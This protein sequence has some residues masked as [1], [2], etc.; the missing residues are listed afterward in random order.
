VA[1]P[2]TGKI[3]RG[4]QKQYSLVQ[5]ALASFAVSLP[6][7]L[8]GQT[9]HLE[10]DFAKLTYGDQGQRS[11]QKVA[12]SFRAADREQFYV[13]ASRFK[14]ALTIYTDDKRQLLAAVSKS[15][16]PPSATDLVAKQ[17][18]EKS[19]RPEAEKRGGPPIPEAGIEDVPKEKRDQKPKT[20]HIHRRQ[21]IHR[22][23][24][25]SRS[26]RITV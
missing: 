4:M 24:T 12:E 2:E 14:E 9:M 20:I 11:Q 22:R 16:E 17:L 25:Q 18:S 6:K 15:S 23:I 13:S 10:P 7:R 26:N 5:T 8:H 1:I 3:R 19:G 21:L